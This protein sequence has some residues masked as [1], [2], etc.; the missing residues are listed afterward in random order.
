MNVVDWQ[1]QLA[2]LIELDFGL[3]DEL[4]SKNA[5]TERQVE[6]VRSLWKSGSRDEAVDKLLNLTQES[7][8]DVKLLECLKRTGQKH[9]ANFVRYRG[10]CSRCYF[11]GHNN[12][13]FM[14]SKCLM[15]EN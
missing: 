11:V 8:S 6:K 5:L 7:D 1:V 14:L 2:D 9:V 13:I 15:I 10:G 3:L 12:I 4:S